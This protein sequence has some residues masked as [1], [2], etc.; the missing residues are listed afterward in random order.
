MARLI[1]VRDLAQAVAQA[2]ATPVRE[3]AAVT[4]I[5]LEIAAFMAAAPI[6]DAFWAM[7][8]RYPDPPRLGLFARWRR[9]RRRRAGISVARLLLRW[10]PDRVDALIDGRA[11]ARF[12]HIH[13]EPRSHEH[14]ADPSS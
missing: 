12:D 6:G 5:E 14:A 8:L 11:I 9:A 2:G 7:R 13:Q 4:S 1:A 10:T 3:G